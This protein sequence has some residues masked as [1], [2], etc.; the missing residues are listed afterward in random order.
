MKKYFL[1]ISIAFATAGAF[2][3]PP[4]KHAACGKKLNLVHPEG[5]SGIYFDADCTTVYVLPPTKSKV[6]VSQLTKTSNIRQCGTVN[7]M[8][9]IQEKTASQLE[10]MMNA[11]NLRKKKPGFERGAGGGV[12]DLIDGEK[13]V[14]EISEADLEKRLKLVNSFYKL[15]QQLQQIV[16]LYKDEPA[17][18][19]VVRF[20][21]P[22]DAL[23]EAYS[24]QNKI[25]GIQ[26]VRMPIDA[27]YLTFNRKISKLG[28]VPAVIGYDIPGIEAANSA[29][30]DS[31][32]DATSDRSSLLVGDSYSG[33]VMLSLIGACPFYDGNNNIVDGKD[34]N[35]ISALLNA[36]LNFSFGL[37]VRRKYTVEYN[38][39]ML[40]KR[41]RE[42]QSSG[43]FFSTST[44]VSEIN[45]TSTTD[46]FA[47]RADSEDARFNY[48]L[49]IPTLKADLMN[50]VIR[51]IA[52]ASGYSPTDLP[53]VQ[54][55]TQNGAQ[56]ASEAL[57]KC[58]HVYCQAGALGLQVL[59]S[60]F[61]SSSATSTYINDRNYKAE[62]R[63]DEN[64]V[65][66]FYGSSSFVPASAGYPFGR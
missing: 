29:I 5:S 42:S 54:A 33:Q 43:G 45:S 6:Y 48:E 53:L 26:Y 24:K 51:D 25:A 60:I 14:E 66:R 15:S 8:L 38:L 52:L 7:S 23:V 1:G 20:E 22:W 11:S 12:D 21:I 28:T 63:I 56:A 44:S 31:K 39:G 30:G 19:A 58:P 34:G 47:L 17:A 3:G 10:E 16:A 37:Q 64:K 40:V 4:V 27:A 9:S 50:R 13:P 36:N 57:Q 62:D 2:A 41:I 65:I 55:R 49:D 32:I 46:W 59:D 18:S 61:G 35:S